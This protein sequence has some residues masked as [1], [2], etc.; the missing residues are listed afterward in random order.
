MG[1]SVSE[2]GI[3]KITIWITCDATICCLINLFLESRIY[4]YMNV[5]ENELN[6]SHFPCVDWRKH[7]YRST[8]VQIHYFKHQELMWTSSMQTE[9][10]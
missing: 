8:G 5:T 1:A 2:V 3:R 10:N 9:N 4:Q 6:L 7:N